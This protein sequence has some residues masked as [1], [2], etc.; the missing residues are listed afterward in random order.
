[1]DAH[2]EYAPD[3][4]KSCVELI[5]TTGADNVG[6]PARTKS[7]TYL[8]RAIAAAFHSRF[9]V[10]GARFHRTDYEGVVDTVV[11]GCWRREVF[12]RFGYFD[13]ELT[14]NQDDEHNLRITRGG[15]KIWQSP[16]IR[17]WYHPRGSIA[18]LFNQY[19]QYGYWKVR[20]IQ[21][22]RLPASWRHLV[23]GAF[24]LALLLCLGIFGLALTRARPSLALVWPLP[25][26]VML[27]GACLLVA[28]VLTAGK[29]GWKLLPVLPVVFA[30]FHFGYGCGFLLGIWDFMIR[31]RG[32]RAAF[33]MLCR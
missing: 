21:K 9:S 22:H 8:E 13:E 3:Y 25:T 1:M 32:P 11:Y 19:M 12:E 29:N 30:G 10:G 6:G 33:Q 14:R 17:S 23:P 7:E 4:I 16:K 18:L 2:T 24:L 5:Q 28:S 31:R 20:V 15:G 26:L 27:Y